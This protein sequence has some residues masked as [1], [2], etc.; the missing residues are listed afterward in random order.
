MELYIYEVKI[1]A[2]YSNPIFKDLSS[3]NTC[4]YARQ[5]LESDEL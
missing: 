2:N 1:N 3:N 4:N 5:G